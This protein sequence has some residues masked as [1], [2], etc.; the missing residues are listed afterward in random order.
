MGSGRGWWI[1][2]STSC[3]LRDALGT[4]IMNIGHGDNGH[5]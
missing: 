3:E 4:M 2:G 1:A 5:P